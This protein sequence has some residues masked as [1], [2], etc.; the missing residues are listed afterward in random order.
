M[1]KES[2]RINQPIHKVSKAQFW[3]KASLIRPK[4]SNNSRRAQK[5]QVNFFPSR[6]S[7]RLPSTW[8]P[9]HNRSLHICDL[10]FLPIVNCLPD[11]WATARSSQRELF[12]NNSAIM[13]FFVGPSIHLRM[14]CI[15]GLSFASCYGILIT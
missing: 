2:T 1:I 4:I 5:S 3:R 15:L 8:T 11:A 9:K 12:Q 14:I 7:D 10:H 13:H 6:F